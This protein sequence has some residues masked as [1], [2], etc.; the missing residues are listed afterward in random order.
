MQS[1]RKWIW[2]TV[3]T[4][5]VF[6]LPQ[7]SLLVTKTMDWIPLGNSLNTALEFAASYAILGVSTALTISP[8]LVILAAIF[9]RARSGPKRIAMAVGYVVIHCLVMGVVLVVSERRWITQAVMNDADYGRIIGHLLLAPALS[10]ASVFPA[11]A[12]QF[13]GGWTITIG[14]HEMKTQR[15]GVL[16]L[17]EWVLV[18]ALIFS[19]VRASFAVND[20]SRIEAFFYEALVVMLPA[21]GVGIV[22]VL[23]LR[24]ILSDARSRGGFRRLLLIALIQV[25]VFATAFIAFQMKDT[26]LSLHWN[27]QLSAAPLSTCLTGTVIVGCVVVCLRRLGYRLRSRGELRR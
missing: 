12:M 19:F 22:A 17:M 6:G 20:Q 15:V 14:Q 9:L 1:P 10:F 5:L 8:S 4:L 27:L 25:A 23:L 3:L 18:S 26:S 24:G 21:V 13:F 16:V 11:A 2:W 7:C